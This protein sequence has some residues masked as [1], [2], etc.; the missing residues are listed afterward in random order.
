MNRE[1]AESWLVAFQAKDI[2]LLRLAD[3]FVHTSPFGEVR[4]KEFYLELVRAN[5]DA[6]FENSIDVIDFLDCGDRFAVRY[7]VGE[8]QACD[9]IYVRGERI[10]EVYSYYHFGE[11]PVLE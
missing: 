5:E 11:K 3:D 7:V 6:F 9:V 1:I 8:M 10:A 2:S 4:G